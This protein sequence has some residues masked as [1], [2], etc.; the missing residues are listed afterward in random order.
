ME[1]FTKLAFWH[2]I[3]HLA[4]MRKTHILD[5]LTVWVVACNEASARQLA[6]TLFHGASP[7]GEQSSTTAVAEVQ[8]ERNPR[9]IYQNQVRKIATWRANMAASWRQRNLSRWRVRQYKMRRKNVKVSFRA[10]SQWI[11][12]ILWVSDNRMPRGVPKV[13]KLYAASSEPMKD[14]SKLHIKLV[15]TSKFLVKTKHSSQKHIIFSQNQTLASDNAQ[16]CQ[17]HRLLHCLEN[18]SEINSK[19]CYKN[20]LLGNRNTFTS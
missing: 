4:G 19:H 3:N 16:T 7:R 6:A 20:H 2:P 12:M 8:M 13:C 18:T 5:M 17:I 9:K 11:G 10:I 1:V 14:N 15:Q